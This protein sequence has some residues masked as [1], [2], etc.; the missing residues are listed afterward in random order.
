MN[1][2]ARIYNKKLNAMQSRN[3]GTVI[4]KKMQ[5]EIKND[6]PTDD[7]RTRGRGLSR[8][9]LLQQEDCPRPRMPGRHGENSPA[10][11]LPETQSD[12]PNTTRSGLVGLVG[13]PQGRVMIFAARNTILIAATLTFLLIALLLAARAG[14]V[15]RTDWRLEVC[16][17]GEA[18][19]E[20][21]RQGTYACAVVDV[22]PNGAPDR[23]RW[24]AGSE[25]RLASRG[26]SEQLGCADPR[27]ATKPAGALF[28][29]RP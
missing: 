21:R 22:G 13:N 16:L 10:Q 19:E 6:H 17:I 25:R 28:R 18:A 20:A 27:G 4:G 14:D 7:A 8:Q 2:A 5:P 24:R 12:Q 23:E 3:V 29:P 1:L 26:G 15:A 9:R 11:Q